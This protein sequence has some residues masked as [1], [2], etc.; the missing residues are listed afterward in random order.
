VTDLDTARSDSQ[1]APKQ[2]RR[3]RPVRRAGAAAADRARFLAR[4]A[5]LRT[6]S[7]LAVSV[8]C[9]LSFVALYLARDTEQYLGN[10]L[11]NLG[12][13]FVGA[14]VTYALVN[15]LMT[16]AETQREKILDHFDQN[17]MNTHVAEAKTIVR[18]FE[19]GVPMLDQPYRRDFLDACRGAL[20]GGVKLEV[21]LLDPD[22]RAAAQRAEELG[23]ALDVRLLIRENLREFQA[24]HAELNPKVQSR[25]ELRVYATAPLAAYYRWDQ[26][27]LISFFPTDRSSVDT[28]QYETSADSNFAQFVE[29]RFQESWVAPNTYDLRDYFTARVGVLRD[30]A[31]GGSGSLLADWV[32]ADGRLYL[33]HHELNQH[34]IEVGLDRVAV[35][36]D[37]A[38]GF[39]G[40]FRLASCD[41]RSPV[42]RLFDHKYGP[43]P[44]TVLEAVTEP[45]TQPA[46]LP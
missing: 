33:V 9:A 31:D 23:S 13:S 30:G 20:K 38:Q 5:R 26:R 8:L 36:L 44:R 16:R 34:V 24:L 29:Q 39:A 15:P 41:S 46:T 27:A 43:Q 19:T 12:A 42:H 45:P 3:S 40:R 37:H 25:F 18:I 4:L 1:E 11:L 7:I 2:P 10:L 22:C 14:V 6:G 17:A 35:V 32:L 21:L 28:T